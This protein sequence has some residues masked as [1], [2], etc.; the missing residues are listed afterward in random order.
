MKNIKI[1]AHWI[2]NNY[3]V[4]VI[5][6]VGINHN[7]SF[8][9]AKKM[10]EEAKNAG[11]DCI[12]FQT[13]IAEKEMINTKL[14]PGNL[15]KKS[16]WE[17]IKSCE[18]TEREEKEISN[19][20]KKKKILFMST[21]FSME[22]VDRLEK[23]KVKGYKIGS[24]E[25]TNLPLLYHIAKTNKPIILSTGM[26]TMNEISKAVKIFKKNKNPLALLQ[27]SSTYPSK[28]NEIKLGLIEKFQKKFL[29]PIGIS[30]HSI[31][32]YTA[33]GAVAK[34]AS[35]VEKHFTLDKKMPGPD[36]NFSLNPNELSELIRGCKAIKSA[37]GDVKTILPNEKQII[38]FAHASVVSIKAMQKNEKFTIENIYTKRPNTGS[39][40][41]TQF[42]KILGRKAKKPI[43]INYQ[44]KWSDMI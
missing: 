31:G 24:G 6:E 43:K 9:L 28:Y 35:I 33:L 37:L 44:L 18:L 34:G 22:A 40:S 17:I 15:S 1:G 13:H 36:Q 20:C 3:P 8:K 11:A 38:K 12:K 14:K 25:L 21:P 23:I 27:T 41:D 5:A 39:I 29:V 42:Y 7:G 30:D 2:G 16:L 32:I 26:S 10:I 4:F 19:F